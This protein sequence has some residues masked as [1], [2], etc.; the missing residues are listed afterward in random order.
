MFN[1]EQM[2]HMDYLGRVS[3]EKK[4]WCGWYVLGQTPACPHCPP[5]KTNADRIAAWCHECHGDPRNGSRPRNC[6]A[7]FM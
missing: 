1:S 3:P 6:R 2:A 5:G 7:M 4:C